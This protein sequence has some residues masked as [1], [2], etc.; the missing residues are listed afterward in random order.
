MQEWEVKQAMVEVQAKH[1]ELMMNMVE[2]TDMMQTEIT[3]LQS[4]LWETEQNVKK[5][6]TLMEENHD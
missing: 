1:T 4:K 3:M 2:V 6:I 5:L